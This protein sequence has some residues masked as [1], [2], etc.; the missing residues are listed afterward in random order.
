[1][2]AAFSRTSIGSGST[3]DVTVTGLDST[4]ADDLGY[5][6]YVYYRS[7]AGLFP[8]TYAVLDDLQTKHGLTLVVVTHNERLAAAMGRTVRLVD[9][10]LE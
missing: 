8:H 1:M 7:G 4:Y 2:R 3:I 9:G 10:R 6:L 5:D